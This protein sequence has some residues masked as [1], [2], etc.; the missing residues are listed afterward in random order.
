MLPYAMLCTYQDTSFYVLRFQSTHKKITKALADKYTCVLKG[1]EPPPDANEATDDSL[2][3]LKRVM[4]LCGALHWVCA[5]P[6]P[7]LVFDCDLNPGLLSCTCK[8][9][10][11][12]TI[13]SHI[14]AV[15]ALYIP[16]TYSAD[17]LQD[18]LKKLCKKGKKKAHRP[19]NA[20]GGQ[21]M[22]PEG[23]CLTYALNLHTYADICLLMLHRYALSMRCLC[24]PMH[25]YELTAGLGGS[26]CNRKVYA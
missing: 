26:I 24:L 5:A 10:R 19:R 16:S 15:T 6:T 3:N 11:A 17:Y 4:E 20:L 12:T 21:Y 1:D 2:E 8:S 13:C 23:I 7:G 25:I 9:S 18:L 14:I 22:Q